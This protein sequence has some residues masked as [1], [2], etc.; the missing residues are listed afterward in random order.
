MSGRD[1]GRAAT[2][3]RRGRAHRLLFTSGKGGVGTSNLVLNLAI[4]LGEMDQRVV[5]VDADIGLANLDLLCGL[6]PRYDLG[7]VLAGRCRLADAIV[8]GP[9]EI[10]IV[11]GAHAIRTGGRATWAT[12]PA[13]LVAELGELEAESDFV[14]VD[15]GSGLGPGVGTAGR[16]GRPGGH[17]HHAR[18][19]L[20][21][22]RAR[23]DQPVPPAGRP[24]AA[25]GA[26]QPGRLG[27]RGRRRPRPAGRLEPA[28]PRRGGFTAGTGFGPGRSSRAAG[29]PQPPAVRDG[30]SGV[31][32]LARRPT[33]GP[34]ALVRERHPPVRNAA[35]ASSPRSPPAGRCRA[36][37]GVRTAIDRSRRSNCRPVGPTVLTGRRAVVRRQ[38]C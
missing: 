32:R 1:R 13:R 19:D 6:T 37:R 23:G 29:R 25:A 3:R 14:L 8:T 24:A 11:P 4:A 21:R 33:A 2:D 31:G 28:V 26:G 34:G 9:G 20:D 10:Q 36:V 35:P 18:A 30:L 27:R 7:D 17:R 5:V 15:A 38:K 12:A 22:R 16:G